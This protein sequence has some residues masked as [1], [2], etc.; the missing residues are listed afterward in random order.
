MCVRGGMHV[1]ACEHGRGGPGPFSGL[2]AHA[3]LNGPAA[4][5]MP[6]GCPTSFPWED[7]DLGEMGKAASDSSRYSLPKSR[8]LSRW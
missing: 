6:V 7:S 2:R 8:F 4:Q 5:A 1:C 3:H